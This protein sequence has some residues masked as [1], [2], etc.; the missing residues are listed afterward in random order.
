MKRALLLAVAVLIA[1][2]LATY[3]VLTAPSKLKSIEISIVERHGNW[4]G[5][6]SE[7]LLSMV[8]P[9]QNITPETVEELKETLNSL[10]WVR[11]SEVSASGDV[12]KVRVWETRPS[13]YIFYNGNTYVIGEND[14]VLDRVPGIPKGAT[15]LYYSGK[16]PPFTVENGFLKLKKTVKMEIKLTEDKVKQLQLKGKPPEILFTDT[17]VKLILGDNKVLVYLSPEANS[18]HN[19]QH[20]REMAEGLNPGIYDFRFHDMLVRGRQQ[21]CLN[22]KS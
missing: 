19:F 12:L 5:R 9:G 20:F 4:K 15:V 2:G 21:K 8:Q 18:W 13:L 6:I 1:V 11:R 17:G 22:R 14:F 10:P 16:T 3:A 7:F